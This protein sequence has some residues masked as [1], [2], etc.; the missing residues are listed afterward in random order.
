MSTN[1]LK[2]EEY[3]KRNKLQRSKPYVY[4]KILNFDEKIRRGESIAIILSI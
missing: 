1:Q 3:N 2:P 4:E